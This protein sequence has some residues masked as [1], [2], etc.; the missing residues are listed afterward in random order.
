MTED[1]PRNSAALSEFLWRNFPGWG[2]LT[3]LFVA[4]KYMHVL[5]GTN[6]LKYYPQNR[7]AANVNQPNNKPWP[8]IWISWA[9]RYL[10]AVLCLACVRYIHSQAARTLL[11]NRQTWE[12]GPLQASDIIWWHQESVV[13]PPASAR[14]FL[15]YRASEHILINTIVTPYSSSPPPPCPRFGKFLSA[16]SCTAGRWGTTNK[17]HTHTH[18]HTHTALFPHHTELGT[19]NRTGHSMCRHA[20]SLTAYVCMPVPAFCTSLVPIRRSGSTFCSQTAGALRPKKHAWRHTSTAD[21]EIN[22]LEPERRDGKRKES[23][24]RVVRDI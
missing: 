1:S 17:A 3:N 24:E 11:A 9:T 18:T 5:S 2:F 21:V 14:P 8:V 16:E 19:H 4:E 20:D 12:Y 10:H 15:S 6:I 7:L 13:G 23:M 22:H